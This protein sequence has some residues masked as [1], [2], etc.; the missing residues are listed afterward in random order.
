MTEELVQ[1]FFL[2]MKVLKRYK[3]HLA[4]KKKGKMIN[5]FTQHACISW[6]FFN[7]SALDRQKLVYFVPLINYSMS[8]T[9]HYA[10]F[11]KHRHD[12][13]SKERF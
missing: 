2:K 3:E 13:I 12:F 1:V 11:L 8:F 4:T 5:I 10:L 7:S 9:H 6:S